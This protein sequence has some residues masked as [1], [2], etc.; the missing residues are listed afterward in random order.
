MYQSRI[1]AIFALVSTVGGSLITK[2]VEV[3]LLR[4]LFWVYIAGFVV[5]QV[6]HWELRITEGNQYGRG[7][8]LLEQRARELKGGENDRT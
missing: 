6:L 1:L 7:G 2:N 3:L 4:F 8:R 5:N